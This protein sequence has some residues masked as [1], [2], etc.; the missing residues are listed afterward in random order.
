MRMDAPQRTRSCFRERIP[1]DEGTPRGSKQICIPMTSDMYHR[2]WDHAGEVRRFLEALIQTAP[3]LFPQGMQDSFQLTGRLPESEK[4]PGIRLRQVRLADGRVFTLRPSFV[5]S[6]MTGT[7]EELEHPLL[8]LSLGVPCWVVTTIF[9]HNDMYWHRHLER[10][11]RNSLVGTTVPNPDRLPEHLAADEHHA[12]WCGEKGYVAFTVGAGCVLGVALSDSA[13]EEHLT[14]AY[15]QFSQESRDVNP[16][17]APKTVNTDGWVATRNAFRVLFSTIV[18][19]LCF[20][21]GFLKIRDRCRKARELHDR[22]WDVYR[23]TTASDF[24]Q[25]MARFRAWCQQG[26]WPKAVLEMVAK[27]WNRESDYVVSYTHPGC[28]RTSNLVDRLMNRLTRFLYAG[29]GL[30]GHQSS[31]ERRLRGWALLQN[32]RPFA[33]RSGER[34][35]YQSPAHRLNQKQYHVH[36]L[37][38]LQV[39]TSLAGVRSPT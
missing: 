28:H 38:N 33:P 27:L 32:F 29:R 20:L 26:N 16:Q 9:G 23:A 8:L 5:M 14:D 37:H 1:Q 35:Q 25:R 10:L 30:H 36:W 15:G 2:I 39:C 4:M 19:V 21:H 34:R 18:P 11:G 17:Y 3:E 12:D 31:C 6:Y 7:V 22:V 24:R 13:D